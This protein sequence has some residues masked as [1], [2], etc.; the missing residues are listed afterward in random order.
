MGIAT[1]KDVK[2]SPEDTAF[3][4]NPLWGAGHGCKGGFSAWEFFKNTGV[5]TGGDYMESG[6]GTSCMAYSLAPCAHVVNASAE[7]P[8]CPSREYRSPQ[9]HKRCEVGYAGSFNRDKLYAT[10]SYSVR[11]EDQIIKELIT[12]GPL[13]V[14]FVVYKDFLTYKSGVYHH[15]P[16]PRDM[17]NKLGGHAVT[18]VGYGVLNGTKYW[19]IKNSWNEQ[20]GDN[21]HFL[22]RRGADEVGIESDVSAGEVGVATAALMV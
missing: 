3:C 21:G 13:F 12:K 22:I 5:V 11:G 18:L 2:Y 17:Y 14:A 6:T 19:K 8:K 9:C 16:N 10:T 20:W 15:P 1:G 4:Q 7:Y